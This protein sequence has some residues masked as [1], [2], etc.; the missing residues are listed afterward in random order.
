MNHIR[1]VHFK[2]VEKCKKCGYECKSKSELKI[3]H[4]AEHLGITYSCVKCSYVSKRKSKLKQ[5]ILSVHKG[6]RFSCSE[7]NCD[8]QATTNYN[9]KRHYKVTHGGFKLQCDLCTFTATQKT[10]LKK[11]IDAKH[12]GVS[13][14]CDRC[15][16]KANLKQGLKGHQNT[17]HNGISYGCTECDYKA[18]QKVNLS[19]HV[20]N[21]H[22]KDLF[23][24]ALCD[25]K[26]KSHGYVLKHIKR[27]HKAFCSDLK[28]KEILAKFVINNSKKEPEP[29][30]AFDNAGAKLNMEIGTSS[31]FLFV[32][33]PPKPIQPKPVSQIKPIL[34]PVDP[35][36][37]DPTKDTF[38]LTTAVGAKIEVPTIIT[39]G[40]DFDR[41]L[42]LFCERQQFKNDKTLINHLLNHFGVAP[43]MATCPICGLF[44]TKEILCTTC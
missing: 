19:T 23:S 10:H 1:V 16:F 5:H 11:H 4:Q 13:Y 21:V 25:F 26:S 44:F 34:E 20:S 33:E 27:L 30:L 22:G 6:V 9:L 18:S 29:V 14:D 28:V 42:C 7:P 15:N 37:K 2:I 8:F 24:C 38:T 40:Y 43:K 17:K 41:L 35:L 36:A 32:P 3:H 31:T 39:G 12:N